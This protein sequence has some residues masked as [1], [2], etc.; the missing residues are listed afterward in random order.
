MQAPLI[1]VNYL[2]FRTCKLNMFRQSK[3]KT[4]AIIAL[5]LRG[6]HEGPAYKVEVIF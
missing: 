1:Q 4:S 3:N 2:A 6:Y 5:Y